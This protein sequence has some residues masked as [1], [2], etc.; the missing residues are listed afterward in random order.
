MSQMWALSMTTFI[1]DFLW[2]Q[3][4]PEDIQNIISEIRQTSSTT[5]D[6]T[7]MDNLYK[8]HMNDYNPI[9]KSIVNFYVTGRD[10]RI[11]STM[12]NILPEH[13]LNYLTEFI[14]YAWDSYLHDI[15]TN[16]IIN[17]NLSKVS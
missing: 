6:D 15:H 1:N 17:N 12:F 4:V 14:T 5:V 8:L 13:V 9:R 11:A 3:K 2:A 16:F 7:F 10:L